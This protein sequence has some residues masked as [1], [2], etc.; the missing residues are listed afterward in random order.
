M[1]RLLTT[2][3]RPTFV[4]GHWRKPAVRVCR[5]LAR[6][7]APLEKNDAEFADF[8]LDSTCGFDLDSRAGA[9]MQ[10]SRRKANVL[11]KQLL[12]SDVPAEAI[13]AAVAA[14]PMRSMLM[15]PK[16]H[17]AD[18]ERAARYAWRA[19]VRARER[20]RER[21]NAERGCAVCV[22]LRARV[23]LRVSCR[24][25]TIQKNV[26][27]MQKTIADFKKVHARARA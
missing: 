2:Q 1:A 26:A 8:D 24:L 7:P 25:D 3:T 21:T 5:C 22:L 9:G 27:R 10:M 17:K 20:E 12:A 15:P 11:R 4:H 23:S 18:R 16:G 19:C 13:P 6:A 14:K